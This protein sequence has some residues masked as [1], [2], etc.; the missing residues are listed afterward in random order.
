MAFGNQ[1]GMHWLVLPPIGISIL[2]AVHIDIIPSEG[3]YARHA[4]AAGLLFLVVGNVAAGRA[5]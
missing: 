2:L 4:I 1:R 5:G 3:L